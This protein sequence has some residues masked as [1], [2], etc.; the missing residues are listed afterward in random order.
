MTSVIVIR[1][2][3]TVGV[4]RD[5]RETMEL[6]GLNRANH[7]VVIP[8]NDSY[9]GMLQKIKDYCTWGEATEETLVSLINARGKAV[10]DVQVD[11]AYVAAHSS[12]GS[13]AEL[14]KALASGEA[15]VKDVE[16]MKPVF[17]LHPPMKGYEGNK[18]SFKE[19]GALGYRGEAISDLVGR[20]I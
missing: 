6:I 4:R 12:F 15:K 14:A 17:R 18:H 8:M 19:G 20:M 16:G 3:A 11:D 5:I 1:V 2:R 10:G 13:V 7:A 9:K